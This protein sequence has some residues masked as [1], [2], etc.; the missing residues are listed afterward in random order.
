MHKIVYFIILTSFT[1]RSP[2]D[3]LAVL[4]GVKYTST[5]KVFKV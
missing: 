1:G 4:Q 5:G 3:Q 2:E